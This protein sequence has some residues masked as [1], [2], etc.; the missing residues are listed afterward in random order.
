M[1]SPCRLSDRLLP[2][3][4]TKTCVVP[5][6]SDDDLAAEAAI[7][8]LG[9]ASSRFKSG[10]VERSLLDALG[11]SEEGNGRQM[12]VMDAFF[13][14]K[15]QQVHHGCNSEKRNSD[16]KLAKI[17]AALATK[18]RESGDIKKLCSSCLVVLA[19]YACGQPVAALL[20]DCF[21]KIRDQLDIW[22]ENLIG[23]DREVATP[24]ALEI[25]G[26]A[27]YLI[28]VTR[29]RAAK[30]F[31]LLELD[32]IFKLEL[33][34][35]TLKRVWEKL[36]DGNVDEGWGSTAASDESS[37]RITRAVVKVMTGLAALFCHHRVDNKPAHELLGR[38]LTA[39]IS[40]ENAYCSCK[41]TRVRA[42]QAD[43]A[44]EGDRPAAGH[45]HHRAG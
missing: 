17:L 39:A 30:N 12:D 3:L 7:K 14:S 10:E 44:R 4:G 31:E 38:C 41:L 26:H 42:R 34:W 1:P 27:I 28:D 36:K 6:L 21:L 35:K 40:M 23:V 15:L 2:L 22:L 43:R 20:T 16:P 19:L 18:L 25:L 32:G 45:R 13:I 8:L 33:L 11:G 9:Q 24:D 37:H 29:V 5:D